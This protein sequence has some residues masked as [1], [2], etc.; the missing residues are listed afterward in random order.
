[1]EASELQRIYLL[2]TAGLDTVLADI[3]AITSAFEQ[4]AKAR[5]ELAGN[6]GIF[7]SSQLATVNKQLEQMLEIQGELLSTLKGINTESSKTAPAFQSIGK[8][9]ESAADGISNLSSS[10]KTLGSNLTSTTPAL[11]R[12][13]TGLNNGTAKEYAEA[14]YSLAEELVELHGEADR[15]TVSF[16]HA[17]RQ[18]SLG[19]I[20]GEELAVE[21]SNLTAQLSVNKTAVKDV[22]A[23]MMLLNRTNNPAIPIE[24]TEAYKMQSEELRLTAKAT[25]DLLEKQ[26]ELDAMQAEINAKRKQAAYFISG[27]ASEDQIN[28]NAKE[29][30]QLEAEIDLINKRNA[31][32]QRVRGNQELKGEAYANTIEADASKDIQKQLAASP[33]NKATRKVDLQEERAQ[34]EMLKNQAIMSNEAASAYERW[35]A[36]LNILKITLHHVT[37][38]EELNSVAT[39][40]M[41]TRASMLSVK[42]QE[43]DRSMG[44]H[45]TS[46]GN[47]G[48]AIQGVGNV[49]NMFFRQLARGIGSLVI[50]GVLF[51]LMG[52]LGGKIWDLVPGTDAV[53]QKQKELQQVLETTE[54]TLVGLVASSNDL[55]KSFRA[56]F[57]FG[58]AA[59]Q[60]YLDRLKGIGVVKDAA[61]ESEKEQFEATQKLSQSKIDELDRQYAKYEKINALYMRVDKGGDLNSIRE[62]MRKLDLSAEEYKK[63][64]NTLDEF[65]R[66][67]REASAKDAKGM[68]LFDNNAVAKP[69][70]DIMTQRNKLQQ[71]KDDAPDIFA[72]KVADKQYQ[73]HKELVKQ[74]EGVNEQYRVEKERL[75][76]NSV[77]KVNEDIDKKTKIALHDLSKARELYRL[78]VTGKDNTGYS[79]VTTQIFD[80]II[81]KITSVGYI[82]KINKAIETQLRITL[83]NSAFEAN[84]ATTNAGFSAFAASY[85]MASYAKMAESHNEDTRAKKLAAE[86]EA[87]QKEA[88]ALSESR[89]AAYADHKEEAEKFLAT[90]T[91]AIEQE[92]VGKIEQIE[93]ESYK[94]RLA[95]G[96]EY[97]E[98]ITEIGDKYSKMLIMEQDTYAADRRTAIWKGKGSQ[99]HKEKKADKVDR[100][101]VIADAE[102]EI[103]NAQVDLQKLKRETL[104]A[105]MEDDAARL[106]RDK[107]KSVETEKALVA[108]KEKEAKLENDI[109]N[110]KERAA[111][112]KMKKKDDTVQQLKDGMLSVAQ[113]A[114]D[115]YF[116]LLSAQDAYRQEMAQRSLA[117]NQKVM[118]SELQSNNEKLN[119]ERASTLASEELHKEAAEQ[120]KKRAKQQIIVNAVIGASKAIAD[121][122][123]PE[124]L[125]AA[126]TILAQAA[127]QEAFLAKAPAYAGG[128][129]GRDSHPGG[130]AWVG[131]GGEREVILSPSTPTLMNLSKGSQVIPMSHLAGSL[132]S[133]L[134]APSFTSTSSFGGG[135]SSANSVDHA[136]AFAEIHA[137]L[138]TVTK[139]L[140]NLSINYDARKAQNAALKASY[141]TRT[142]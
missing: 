23:A 53:I 57:G 48:L 20:S 80:S 133:G 116:K 28:Q 128:I 17:Q 62:D 89:S 82:T 140:A 87:I 10:A 39:E 65:L 19:I 69:Q 103:R 40:Q 134:K 79:D 107:D 43:F 66:V 81:S 2:K 129:Y 61:Y 60:A 70:L 85:G 104:M 67:K 15:L 127:V 1:M 64:I 13:Q 94:K 50:W 18:L 24:T 12:L 49:Q 110:A 100:Q 137:T 75:D 76:L 90:R 135:G 59:A 32:E 14:L 36:E 38:E 108:L 114:S 119:E 98:R 30:E 121:G 4:S 93:K 122:E 131:D 74:L 139:G 88:Q 29:I 86:N 124:S 52:K 35:V 31:A 41:I 111:R 95:L 25:D 109:A 9:A 22:E 78:S 68:R 83:S 26:I 44:S 132:G 125:V 112:A 77:D 21:F 141:K 113:T 16:Q 136:A 27:K 37:T 3:N 33:A 130:L 34:I 123:W 99:E 72:A 117:W 84:T 120:A 47:Y 73:K 106:S 138:H 55:D 105:T 11:L 45:K 96:L 8:G 58:E 7:D 118:Q 102:E 92:K 56:A 142:I 46:I 115:E 71:E 42:I 97:F 6:K 51:D 63:A 5:A 91:T 126:G 101:N 54:S